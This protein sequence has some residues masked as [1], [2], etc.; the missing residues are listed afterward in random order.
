MESL[1][2]AE[3]NRL[4]YQESGGFR[5]SGGGRRR[6]IV[7]D[8][9]EL[10]VAGA[11]IVQQALLIEDAVALRLVTVLLGQAHIQRRS[12]NQVTV[13]QMNCHFH[14]YFGHF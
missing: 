5:T 7:V 11:E 3:K 12:K 4:I 13:T 10:R 9:G 14:N 6:R 8:D 1:E 2:N